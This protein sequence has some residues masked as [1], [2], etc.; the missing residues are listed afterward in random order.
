[1][2]F[3]NA[4]QRFSNR[5]AD[6]VRYRPG[7]PPAV[8]D[9]LRSECALLPE[10]VISDIG[11]GTG[12]F[13]ELFLRNGNAVFGVEPNAAMRKA[14][15]EYLQ[16]YEH[17]R[18]VDA[19]AEATTLKDTSVDFITAGQA[20][21]WFEPNAARQ[22]FSRIL[23]P[24][25][26]IVVLWNERRMDT[27]FAREYEAMLVRYGTDYTR[28]RDAYPESSHI[29]EFF[30]H[31]N[32]LERNLPHEQL[33][34]CA[35]LAGRLRSSSYSPHEEHEHFPSIM[36]ELRRIFRVHRRDGRVRMEYVT[37]IYFGQLHPQFVHAAAKPYRDQS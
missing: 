23:K 26:W 16:E 30:G 20:F 17:F 32:F 1:M 9:V 5:V 29:Q 25:G 7:Y 21:H 18:S 24:G 34:D 33:F 15:E 10:H 35:G 14:G 27:P 6:Y 8:L 3:A 28:V 37:R 19:S 36:A 12:L 31:G 4:K 13:S 22:E 2:T 11:S